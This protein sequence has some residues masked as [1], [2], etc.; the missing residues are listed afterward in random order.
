MKTPFTGKQADVFQWLL[1]AVGIFIIYKIY[2]GFSNIGSGLGLTDAKADAAADAAEASIYVKADWPAE[3]VKRFTG[4]GI[5]P[6][7]AEA[8]AVKVFTS[9]PYD[10]ARVIYDAKS[11]VRVGVSGL[12]DDEEK[13]LNV[14][15]L[16]NSQFE[17]AGIARAFSTLYKRDMFSYLDTFLSNKT[18]ESLHKIAKVKPIYPEAIKKAAKTWKVKL[19]YIK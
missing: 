1:L 8:L 16:A 4:T 10:S 19:P 13:V 7:E 2:K 14:Y 3:V 5:K 15:R 9:N 12:A 6:K 18:L 17:L 11:A